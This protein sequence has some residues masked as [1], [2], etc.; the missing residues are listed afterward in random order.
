MNITIKALHVNI[1][2]AL[3]EYAQKKVEK[4]LKY[5][6]NV[7]DVVI[8]LDIRDSADEDA[9]QFVAGIIHA[10]QTVIRAEA[11]SRDMYGSIDLVCDK[12]SHQL[13]KHKE[14]LRD[15]HKKTSARSLTEESTGKNGKTKTV[16]VN[17][18]QELYIAKPMEVDEAVDILA[19]QKTAFLMFRN[20]RTEEI[21]VVYPIKKGQF[22]LIEP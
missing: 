8:E 15:H 22:G 5:F 19:E 12:L 2:G 11:E 20:I 13:K 1:T 4:V 7:Q 14:K 21:N 16:T 10:S 17:D 18:E 3:K 9:R 6:D